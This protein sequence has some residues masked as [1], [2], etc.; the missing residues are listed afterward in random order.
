MYIFGETLKIMTLYKY[1]FYSI[2]LLTSFSNAQNINDL[3]EQTNTIYNQN[4]STPTEGLIV[5]DSLLKQQDTLTPSEGIANIY[6][7]KGLLHERLAKYSK[8]KKNSIDAINN[9]KTAIKIREASTPKDLKKINNSLYNIS[10]CYS[11]M[12]NKSMRRKVLESL[13]RSSTDKFVYKS[14]NALAYIHE[15]IGDYYTALEYINKVI[16]SYEFY[17]DPKTLYDAHKAAIYIYSEKSNNKED[18][19]K[20]NTHVQSIENLVKLYDKLKRPIYID[21][22]LAKIYKNIGLYETASKFYNKALTEYLKIN[23]SANASTLYHNLG[24]LYSITKEHSKAKKYFNKALTMV[25]D[26][27]TK[28]GIY[29]NQ[30]AY[31]NTKKSIERLPYFEKAIRILFNEETNLSYTFKLPT[32]EKLKLT[33]HKSYAL[34]YLTE[35][36]NYLVKS[37]EEEKNKTYLK[38]AQETLYKIDQL[39]SLMRYDSS[40]EKSK[41][42]WI[43][44]GVD[45]YMLAVKVSYLLDSPKDAF[46]FMEKNKSLL[47]LENLTSAEEKARLQIP[48]SILQHEFNLRYA[49]LD[50]EDKRHKFPKDNTLTKLYLEKE[51][52]YIN[53]LNSLKNQYP[54][55]FNT[56]KEPT[57]LSL[58]EAKT[59]HTT[60]NTNY[61]EYILNDSSGYG[62]FCSQTET[63]LFEIKDVTKLLNELEV[64]KTLISQPIIYKKDND[65]YN[66]VAFSVFKTIFPFKNA[67]H[68]ISNKKLT[69]IPDYKLR[70]LPFEALITAS[71]KNASNYLI[72]NTEVSYYQSASVFKQIE[73]KKRVA[74]KEL[75]GFAPIVYTIDSLP[76]LMGSAKEMETISNLVPSVI[77]SYK[78]ASKKAFISG[79]NDY[80]VIHVNTHAGLDENKDPWIAFS[81]DKITLKELYGTENQARLVVLD[82]CKTASGLLEKGEGVMSLSRGFFYSGAESVIASQWNVNEQSNNEIL[83]HFYKNLKEGQTKSKALHN[84]KLNYINTHQNTELSPYY[85]SSLI[86]TG[87][88][89]A[90]EFTSFNPFVLKVV[91][92]IIILLILLFFLMKRFRKL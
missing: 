35:Y 57:I 14:Y 15:T 92:F 65:R 50:I 10:N 6:H 49:I 77:L 3:I 42:F 85:W 19:I 30:G 17:K 86:L 22:S 47:L 90:I 69:V 7:R 12:G 21:N 66:A 70:D 23:D 20:I 27:L 28:S 51:N 73:Q 60:A 91:A 74:K 44:K 41:L 63:I 76:S 29:A 72:Q 82:A 75:I 89:D 26:N 56:K 67:L 13:N 16:L 88:P 18:L 45:L 37:Y 11:R 55:Y 24:E 64:L 32:L 43:N 39:V 78:E 5:L 40:S 71:N 9:Y 8:Q 33:S 38:R 58:N 48:D 80:N 52:K 83:V 87:N 59:K 81:N 54:D 84:A 36:A 1:V 68:L 34:I 2:I 61:I 25:K 4:K 46:Y 62:L 53:F 79:L 31:L